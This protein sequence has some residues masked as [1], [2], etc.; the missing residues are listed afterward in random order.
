MEQPMADLEQRLM[1]LASAIEW[2]ATPNLSPR[3]SR[4]ITSPLPLGSPRDSAGRGRSARWVRVSGNW[5]QR[6]W[7]LAAAAVIIAIAGL[8]AYTPSR[9]AVAS[10]LNLHVLIRQ[11]Q[12]PIKPSPLPPGP[13][14]KRLGLGNETTLAAAQTQIGWHIV[15]PAALGSPDEVYL[16]LPPDGPSQGE[17][18][19]VYAARPGIPVSRQTGVSVLVTEARGAVNTNFFG[20]MLGP[21]TTL[22][23][24]TVDGYQGYWIAGQPNVFVFIDAAG[25][26]RDETMRLAANTLILDDRGT[27][28]RI[29]GDLTKDQAVQIARSLA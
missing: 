28:I 19:L 13:L 26:F 25:N 17:V 21:D 23:D 24:V 22:E 7:T 15:I 11:V 27:I 4:L 29:E 20:K 3:V 2:P 16:Q 14:G 8:L 5:Y 12:H 18:T 9:D 1:E 10:W 6:P